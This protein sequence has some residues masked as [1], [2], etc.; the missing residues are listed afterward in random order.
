MQTDTM[1]P[2]TES[3]DAHAEVA[4]HCE[5][6]IS[7]DFRMPTFGFGTW[8]IAADKAAGSV[9]AALDAGY[10][11]IDCA[12]IYGNE[13]EVGL[14]IR[15]ALGRDP[16][17]RD[18]L[19]LT[20]KL[21]NAEHHPSRVRN[22]C[23]AS[24]A[25]LGVDHL[26]LYL[27]HWPVAFKPGVQWPDAVDDIL[28]ID[29]NRL[30]ET[31]SAMESLLDEGLVRCIGVSNCSVPILAGIVRGARQVP[32]VNQVE[33]HP[34]LQQREL[35]TYCNDHGI[36]FSAYSPL[37]SLDRPASLRHVDELRVIDDSC[38]AGIARRHATTP[39][40]VLLAW[41]LAKG[42]SVLCK[43]ASPSRLIEN[44]GA[45]FLV[46]PPEDVDAIDSIALQQRYVSPE[47]W[48]RQGSTVTKE[49]LW[50]CA[51]MVSV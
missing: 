30:L 45:R 29:V 24:I 34:Y 39:A 2:L 42:R 10:R 44:L 28:G 27:I 25:A 40:V 43:S 15:D 7:P 37:G 19:W 50:G 48:F 51:G 5:Y 13:A 20:S 3:H 18:R 35:A 26:D 23:L 1:Q 11:H 8:K 33:C 16:A 21:W 41:H 32:M 31:W 17:M 12:P 46:L 6:T 36:H 38:V 14:A 47:A 4:Q 9:K 49:I 22:A